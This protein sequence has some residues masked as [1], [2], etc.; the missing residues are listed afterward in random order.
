[1]HSHSSAHF[2]DRPRNEVIADLQAI[3]LP[4]KLQNEIIFDYDKGTLGETW[5]MLYKPIVEDSKIGL[6]R[7]NFEDLDIRE[8]LRVVS[9]DIDGF[10]GLIDTSG[11]SEGE[12]YKRLKKPT[13]SSVIYK[14]MVDILSSTNVKRTGKNAVLSQ[15]PGQVGS[16]G[17]NGGKRFGIKGSNSDAVQNAAQFLTDSSIDRLTGTPVSYPQQGHTLDANNYQDLARDYALMRAQQATPNMRDGADAKGLVTM[18]R[19]EMLIKERTKAI[20]LMSSLVN[21]NS[22]KLSDTEIERLS[23]HVAAKKRAKRYQLIS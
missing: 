10:E 3:G 16:P 20:D 19:D 7:R 6:V 15:G 13:R 5:P 17:R 14:D 12:L 18:T 21:E 2:L 22:D 9:D 4:L 23:K 11:L 1:M 8:K